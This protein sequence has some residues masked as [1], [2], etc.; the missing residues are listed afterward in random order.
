[1]LSFV[2]PWGVLIFRSL[3][4]RSVL[5]SSCRI[6]VR[7][8]LNIYEKKP[9]TLFLRLA[10]LFLREVRSVRRNYCCYLALAQQPS[11]EN[12]ELRWLWIYQAWDRTYATML[13]WR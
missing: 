2:Q 3:Q 13:R 8:A 1:M 4:A 9:D 6:V 10:K 11:Y 5:A 7:L 12:W